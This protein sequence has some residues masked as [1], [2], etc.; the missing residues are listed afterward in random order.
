MK[1]FDASLAP[2][3]PHYS[4][5][6]FGPDGRLVRFCGGG[7]GGGSA[8]A[9]NTSESTKQHEENMRQLRAQARVAADATSPKFTPASAPAAASV[10]TIA[11]GLDSRRKNGRRFG[12]A[13][14]ADANALGMLATLGASA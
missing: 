10:D 4:P 6:I 5:D 12:Y 7:G 11:A 3:G 8:P 14:T 2:G 9:P 1:H 13:K